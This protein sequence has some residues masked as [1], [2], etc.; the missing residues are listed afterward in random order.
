MLSIYYH[1]AVDDGVAQITT[2]SKAYFD[3]HHCLDDGSGPDY[4]KIEHA[5]ERSGA[6]RLCES[7]Y[8]AAAES[9]NAVIANMQAL[10]FDMISSPAF[11][12]MLDFE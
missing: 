9:V 6:G 8:E 5:M 4:A 7:I 2:T 3:Q 12:A 1:V 10:G 11:D